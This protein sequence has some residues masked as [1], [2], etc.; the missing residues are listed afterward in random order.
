MRLVWSAPNENN[1]SST[2]GDIFSINPS[3]TT[4]GGFSRVDFKVTDTSSGLVD[5]YRMGYEYHKFN[6]KGI[7]ALE[8]TETGI[9]ITE[10]LYHRGDT[11][12][13]LAFPQGNVI[14]FYAGSETDRRI[15]ITNSRVRFENLSTGV[16]I[17][18]DLD[19][20]GHTNLDNVSIAGVTTMSGDLTITGAQP[21]LNFIDNGQ[22]PDYKLYN[23]NG[24]LRLYDITNTADRL[25]INTDGHVDVTGNLDVGAGIDVTGNANI[26]GDLDV[27]GHTNLD[28]VSV[29]GVTTFA[30]NARFNS[31]ITAGGATGS[32]GQ[33][34]KTTGTGVEWASFPTM[35]TNQTFTASAGQTTFS[36]S[37]T[38]GFLDVFVN[39]VKLSSSE[40]T[41]SNGS[42]VVLSVGSFVGD[43]VELISYYTVSGGGG[44]GGGISNVVEDTTPQ[45]G[46]NL[47][48][49]NK[50]I[51]GTGNINLTGIV[52]AT[53]FV[54][55][56]SG[57][58]GI[59]ASGS[60]VVV[61][62]S[63]SVVGTAGTIDFGDN[64]SVS[65]AS[66]GIVTITGSAGVSTSQFDVNK[67]DVSGISTFKSA[68]DIN[69]DIDV[70]GH[71]NLD[72]V[73]I[74]GVVTATT[75][76]G[77]VTGNVTG[78][79]TGLSGNPSINITDLD[80]DGHTNLDNVNVAGV[81][82]FA[83][84]VVASDIQSNALSLKNA[85]GSATYATFANGGASVL[86]F[87]NT[88]RLA[89]TNA[90]V[91]VTGT[92]SATAFSGD[93][94]AL[95]GISAG[96]TSEVRANTLVVT[97]VSTF[98]DTVTITK[99]ASPL[100]VNTLTTNAAIEIQRS[101]STKAYLTPESGEFRIQTYSSEDIALQT[102]TGG[103]TAGDITFKSVDTEIFKVKGTGN[104][105]IH[106]TVPTSR[107]DVV[108]DAKVSG[109]VTATTFVGALTGNS[110]TFTV[111]A[112]N[113]TNETVYPVFVDGATG[114][115]GAETDTGLNYNPSTGALS[116]LKF[117][118]DG[119]G[120]TGVTGSGTGI[121]IKNSGSVVGTAG[122]INFG[123]NLSVSAIS[124]GS[125]TVTA[126][127]GISTISGVVNIAN[128]LD[129]DG[130]TNLD[131]V[132]VAGVTTFSSDV[133]ISSTGPKISLND[134]NN[135]P[136]YDILNTDGTFQVND[137]TN[138]SVRFRINSGG[139]VDILQNLDVG[140]NIKLGNAGVVTATSFVGDGS[141]LTGVTP[142]I[143]ITTNLSGS[144]T[145]SAGSAAT[146]NTLT[147]Y[148]A[149]D[150]VVE[151]TIYIKN[152]SDFQSQKLLAMRD[153]TTIHSTQF[154]VMFSSSLLVQCDAT[155]SSGNILLRA[156]PETGV[157]GSTT[158]KIKREVM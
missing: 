134:T 119:S 46:G 57:L 47:D 20:D 146:I 29:A 79:A 107:L 10:R 77:A 52:T 88:D 50:S 99:A 16:D 69:A 105:G 90:G 8:V 113:S 70:D 124:G 67:L 132:S 139:R 89:T 13:F 85:A 34:L 17:N 25:V 37:Y 60:G 142:A 148:S 15:N 53:N 61:K 110:D 56:G 40:F 126:T 100:K 112:N 49:F 72:N 102:N 59:T 101:G 21:A 149:N 1:F 117:I 131:N 154:A 94:S 136:D 130:H 109:V 42:S 125:V 76:V 150:L 44:G 48:I 137:T 54:G 27:D 143:G 35:R 63:G 158:Y 9:G 91:T 115:Q 153:G 133:V 23:N 6:I 18:A 122:T 128:D 5:S 111:T 78:N 41:A 14:D 108:G 3:T 80:V 30:A 86:K 74:S 73:S 68:V 145:A 31:T 97:G 4:G 135:N 95:T 75:F 65:P 140:S 93:G 62:N 81:T 114:S 152:G 129:V 127:S 22:N 147:G 96:S 55:D 71:T 82:T 138:G 11:D 84:A 36:F 103:G 7:V 155:I 24:A 83:S 106:S 32:N 43:I 39:G 51:T 123:D 87:N 120:L 141:N 151:Y 28:N 64:L 19:V 116:S 45:L 118:G 38:V 144:F 2:N 12:T 104:V 26:S 98:S 33:Y 157:S 58:T 66:A 156:T 121:A 92:V